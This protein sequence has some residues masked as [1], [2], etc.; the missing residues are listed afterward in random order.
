MK[1]LITLAAV[2]VAS[3]LLSAAAAAGLGADD[4]ALVQGKGTAWGGIELGVVAV[5]TPGGVVNGHVVHGTTVVDVRCVRLST[6]RALVGGVVVA[7]EVPGQ[8]G[9][10]ES[11]ALDDRSGAGTPDRVSIGLGQ[12]AST[13]PFSPADIA[14]PW[15]E[16]TSGDFTIRTH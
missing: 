3:V 11:F 12:G 6:G 7:S 16:L 9:M 4:F 15:E 5:S 14:G 1:R 10:E 8:I 2:G 13:C